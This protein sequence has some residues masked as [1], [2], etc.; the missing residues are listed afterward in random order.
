MSISYKVLLEA[1]ETWKALIDKVTSK[2]KE[3]LFED[4]GHEFGRSVFEEI[5]FMEPQ[6]I[7]LDS[8]VEILISKIDNSDLHKSFRIRTTDFENG[9]AGWTRQYSVHSPLN[10]STSPHL[11]IEIDSPPNKYSFQPLWPALSG[12]PEKLIEELDPLDLNIPLNKKARLIEDQD[13][14]SLFNYLSNPKRRATVLV[15]VVPG[16]KDLKEYEVLLGQLMN[17][18]DGTLT[19]FIMSLQDAGDFNALVPESYTI[20]QDYLRLFNPRLNFEERY[21]AHRHKKFQIESIESQGIERLARQIAS[22]SRGNSVALPISAYLQNRERALDFAENKVLT[23]G[24]R[25]NFYRRIQEPVAGKNLILLNPLAD[26]VEMSFAVG[27]LRKAYEDRYLDPDDLLELVQNKNRLRS[28]SSE[29]S[30]VTQRVEQLEFDLLLLREELDDETL[31]RLELYEE[32]SKLESEIRYLRE[33]LINSKSAELAY[34]LPPQDQ[35][36]T[37]PLS[38]EEVIQRIENL[39][40]VQFTGDL[41]ETLKLDDVDSG[42][43][44]PRCWEYLQALDD[45]ARAKYAKVVEVN[46]MEYLKQT[47]QGF[48]TFS[49]HKF[50]PV[51]SEQTGNRKSLLD[52]R[53]FKVPTEVDPSGRILMES[54]LKVSRR[55]RIHFLDDTRVSGRIYIGFIGNHLPLAN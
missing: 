26:P 11:L 39:V 31:G 16:V 12:M 10:P 21:Q 24:V 42:S 44:A 8:K 13:V 45:Y 9:N 47:P 50:A 49:T 29:L 46:L 19:A 38:F 15:A 17:E 54:H 32:K 55:I 22:I 37:L 34:E 40:F 23:E 48:K 27:E 33:K 7:D 1:D 51:E 53:T 4:F 43:S 2:F 25:K 28:L 3:Q 6:V 30:S 52:A 36:E 20:S 18:T 14:A 5:N 35:Y 41:S